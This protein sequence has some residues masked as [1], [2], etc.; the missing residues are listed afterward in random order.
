MREEDDVV[1]E[2]QT[3]GSLVSGVT[4]DLSALV[5][6]ELELAKT[7]LRD[8]AK[9]A[10]QGSGLLVG[11]GVTAFLGVIFLLLTAAWVLVQLGLPTWAGFGIVT[12]VL[13]IV[14]VILGL[15][16]KKQLENIKGLER[17]QASM[18][19]SKAL[20]ARKSPDLP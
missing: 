8:S 14:A 7:E 6:G 19:K 11:A 4:E 15:V 13:I 16:G 1:S 12:L 2:K 3:L 5:R 18:E 20:L 9:T 10:G 17:S